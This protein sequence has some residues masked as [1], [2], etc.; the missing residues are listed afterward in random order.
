MRAYGKNITALVK[1]AIKDRDEDFLRGAVYAFIGDPE[2]E[3]EGLIGI[4]IHFLGI[5]TLDQLVEITT[6]LTNPGTRPFPRKDI[7]RLILCFLDKA[8]IAVDDKVVA[9]DKR[10]VH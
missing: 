8:N 6:A 2:T 1:T 10:R 5:A 3:N 4:I 7:E 9:I